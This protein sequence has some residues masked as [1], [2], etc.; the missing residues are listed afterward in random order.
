MCLICRATSKIE[1]RAGDDKAREREK[2]EKRREEK[3]E[4]ATKQGGERTAKLKREGLS[5][6]EEKMTE[7]GEKGGG[8]F[9]TKAHTP[10]FVNE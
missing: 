9:P 8:P 10:S 7:K 2:E 6:K 3:R 1:E 4:R 5:E